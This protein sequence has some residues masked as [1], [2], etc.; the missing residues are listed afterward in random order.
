MCRTTTTG[1]QDY[2]IWDAKH[3]KGNV[4]TASDI[5][6]DETYYRYVA[7]GVCVHDPVCTSMH[8]LK[9]SHSQF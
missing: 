8:N 5:N 1:S 4:N 2:N 3:K 7:A 9:L 6:V